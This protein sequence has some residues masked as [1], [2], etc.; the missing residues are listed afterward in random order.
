MKAGEEGKN[1]MTPETGRTAP[2]IAKCSGAQE[3]EDQGDNQKG[4]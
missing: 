1:I 4:Q 2:E 3:G